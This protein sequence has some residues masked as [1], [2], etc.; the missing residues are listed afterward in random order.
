MHRAC[1]SALADAH[2]DSNEGLD[3]CPRVGQDV[4]VERDSVGLEEAHDRTATKGKVSILFSSL[5]LVAFLLS[6]SDAGSQPQDG[7]RTC[8]SASVQFLLATSGTAIQ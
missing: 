8:E 1:S 6:E 5:D 4:F 2:S 7:K 3:A